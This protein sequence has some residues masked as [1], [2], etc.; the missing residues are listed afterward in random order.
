[1]PWIT[2]WV[3]E[4][5]WDA[6]RGRVNQTFTIARSHYANINLEALSEGYPDGYE[7]EELEKL[8]SDVAPLSQALANRIED[9][10]LPQRG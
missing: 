10:V 9:V 8:E 3:H 2:A 4:L 7:D 5:E 6:L 1:M